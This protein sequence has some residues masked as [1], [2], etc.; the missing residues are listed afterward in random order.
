MVR[1]AAAAI[2]TVLT[3]LLTLIALLPMD[4]TVMRL[5]APSLPLV[6]IYY[7]AVHR[8]D[9]MPRI[10]VLLIGL[11]IDIFHATPFGATALAYVLVH[12]VVVRNRR[13]VA[14]KPFWA[15]WAGMAGAA[16]AVYAIQWA[17]TSA[18]QG[19]AVPYHALVSQIGISV[20][21]FPWLIWPLMTM[22]R[23]LLKS[24]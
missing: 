19:M 23:R 4:S 2:P 21:L 5:I 6:A 15:L 8:P 13:H 10:A 7:W 18:F 3:G 1:H 22:Q 16:V 24:I 17:L 11:A 14:G 20:A 12:E 9:L